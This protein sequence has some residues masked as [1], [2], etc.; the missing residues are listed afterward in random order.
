MDSEN[1]GKKRA[2]PPSCWRTG[3]ERRAYEVFLYLDHTTGVFFY[4][5]EKTPPLFAATT[6]RCFCAG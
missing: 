3:G 1:H 6:G 2:S 4:A 5:T